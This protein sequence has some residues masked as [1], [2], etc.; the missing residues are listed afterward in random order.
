MDVP[1]VFEVPSFNWEALLVTI[2]G[3]LQVIAGALAGESSS[4]TEPAL[5]QQSGA[6]LQW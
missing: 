6:R 2:L 3:V 1:E 4:R 5:V